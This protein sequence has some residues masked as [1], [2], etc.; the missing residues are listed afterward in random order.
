MKS[1]KII[2]KSVAKVKQLFQKVGNQKWLKNVIRQVLLYLIRHHLYDI[3]T[4][5]KYILEILFN[6]F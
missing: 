4:W 6:D 5:S 2:R 3:I 1:P